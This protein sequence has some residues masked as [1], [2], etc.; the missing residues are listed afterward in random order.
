MSSNWCEFGGLT[1][2]NLGMSDIQPVDFQPKTFYVCT[3]YIFKGHGS[4]DSSF[5]LRSSFI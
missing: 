3:L 5:T 4:A 1:A 2:V